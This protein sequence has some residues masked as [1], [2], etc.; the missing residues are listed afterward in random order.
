VR[1]LVN[2]GAMIRDSRV[3]Y[4]ISTLF[5]RFFVDTF[6]SKAARHCSDHIDLWRLLAPAS[7]HD[8]V[9]PSQAIRTPR[10]RKTPTARAPEALN[11]PGYAA[12][13]THDLDQLSDD[14]L[15][16]SLKRLTGTANELTAQLL[17]HLAEVEARGIH[18]N[19]AC[20]TLYVYCVYELRMSEDEAQRRCRA[21]R[22]CRQFP[23]LFDMLADASIHLTG[24]LLLGPHLNDE[25][26]RELLARARYRTKREIEK[27]V[28]EIAPLPDVPARIEPL[29][30]ATPA[31]GGHTAMMA[32]LCGHV[33]NLPPGNG[34]GEAPVGALAELGSICET[35]ISPAP[36]PVPEPTAPMPSVLMH[37]KVQFTAD[38]A[39]MALLEEARDLLAHDNPTRDFVAVQRRALEL[40]VAELRKRK[41][42]SRAGAVSER[43]TPRSVSRADDPN[44]E[45]DRSLKD[46]A[47]ERASRS[48]HPRRPPAAIARA[49]WQRD[50]GRCTYVDA[51][52]QRCRET[53]L[54]EYH[55]EHA[56][57]LGGSTSLDNVTLRCRAHNALA[58]ERDFGRQ[59]MERRRHPEREEVVIE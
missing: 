31:P 18:R 24:I 32:A 7:P 44:V 5:V 26:Q 34:R 57:A 58:A 47:V 59:F 45:A 8:G 36:A 25:N 21:A 14:V 29:H 52:G 20:A 23:V 12:S 41:H 1:L 22:L 4:R 54:L 17:A 35:P 2:G 55:H 16:T 33:R 51:R 42:G 15:L 56:Y 43:S 28:A 6:P 48:K 27:L 40:L 39:Y 50:H 11:F 3:N 9:P 46:N 10:I 53:A 49:V 13:M 19:M 37:Y 30:I 38:Q